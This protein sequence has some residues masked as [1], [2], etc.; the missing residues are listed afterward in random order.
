MLISSVTWM[1]MKFRNRW[2]EPLLTVS[3]FFSSASSY[4]LFHFNFS[5]RN[6]ALININ[7]NAY[8]RQQ[9]SECFH[10]QPFNTVSSTQKRRKKRKAKRKNG[11]R[12]K[13]EKKNNVVSSTLSA[14]LCGTYYPLK[15][16]AII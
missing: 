14:S 9:E 8:H 11:V 2:L 15:L 12:R 16:N 5:P 7:V 6:F 13:R 10:F 1:L 3:F 4:A